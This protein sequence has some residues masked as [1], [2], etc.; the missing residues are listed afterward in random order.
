LGY[1]IRSLAESYLDHREWYNGMNQFQQLPAEHPSGNFHVCHYLA[2]LP[3]KLKV[4]EQGS[5]LIPKV[6]Q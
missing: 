5:A 1:L 4:K 3:L 6:H 2:S